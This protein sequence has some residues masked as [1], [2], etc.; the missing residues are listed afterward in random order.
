MS[1][2]C[3]RCEGADTEYSDIT[4]DTSLTA[5][6]TVT[7]RKKTP[8][9]IQNLRFCLVVILLAEYKQSEMYFSCDGFILLVN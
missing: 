6:F 2:F 7:F 8:Q 1:C 9:L 4:S 5:E 3:K